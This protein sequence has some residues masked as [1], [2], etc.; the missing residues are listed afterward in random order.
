V[1]SFEFLTIDEVA[2]LLRTKHQLVRGLI[3]R[4]ELQ[5]FQVG[6][7]RQWRIS[8]EDL[9]AYVNEQKAKAA[10]GL[11]ERDDEPAPT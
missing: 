2:E 3:Q 5:A 11:P 4:G 8:A 7:R 6:G 10:Q 1:A 9:H